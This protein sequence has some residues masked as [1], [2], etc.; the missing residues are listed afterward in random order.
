MDVE[1]APP[2]HPAS[3]PMPPTPAAPAEPALPPES[4]LPDANSSPAAVTDTSAM[5]A[6]AVAPAADARLDSGI[7]YDSRM[8]LHRTLA[9]ET[10]PCLLY[11]SD[12]AD[13]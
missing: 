2:I 10:H 6:G 12:A 1:P 5:A 4:S 13:E 11:T 8:M 7:V 3:W 9:D